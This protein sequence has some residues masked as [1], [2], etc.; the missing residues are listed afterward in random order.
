[1]RGWTAAAAQLTGEGAEY[2]LCVG[3]CGCG[4]VLGNSV[5]GGTGGVH[6]QQRASPAGFNGGDRNS[7]QLL[8]PTDGSSQEEEEEVMK[9]QEEIQAVIYIQYLKFFQR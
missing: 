2:R 6:A 5:K 9:E 1:M 8:G 3:G 4:C 7:N